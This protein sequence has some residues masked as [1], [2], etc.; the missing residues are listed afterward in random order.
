MK[1]TN[2]LLAA[3]L[4]TAS[5][6]GAQAKT[7]PKALTTAASEA[8]NEAAAHSFAGQL[9]E[10]HRVADFLVDVLVLNDMQQHAVE[11]YTIMHRKA[12]ALATT[13]ADI[14]NAQKE[15]I[16][17]VRRVLAPS[18]LTSYAALRQQLNGTMLP[19]DGTELAS[20]K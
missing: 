18:Q 3:L 20:V 7:H 8:R 13:A 17:A 14:E 19:L 10:A 5:L 4:V 2:T 9:H 15:Y 16:L 1:F 12:L 6:S 11:A